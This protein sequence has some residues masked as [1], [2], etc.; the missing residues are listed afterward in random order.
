MHNI[1]NLIT[2]TLYRSKVFVTTLPLCTTHIC[3]VD[4]LISLTIA[5]LKNIDRASQTINVSATKANL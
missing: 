1:V 4:Q 5:H 2:T 3:L